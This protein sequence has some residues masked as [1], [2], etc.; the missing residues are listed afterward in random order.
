MAKG[1]GRAQ[2][3]RRRAASPWRSLYST[4]RW[5][6]IRRAQ[7]SREPTCRMCQRSGLVVA[8]SIVDHVTR[9]E[10]DPVRFFA[11]PFQSLCKPCHDQAKQR[12]ERRGHSDEIGA[13]G[14]PIDPRH[15]A[16]AVR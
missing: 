2:D 1:D 10:G 11:G 13:D 4:E 12:E 14:W 8:A 15:P 3:A 5:Q 7:L 9:H 6:R 16:N